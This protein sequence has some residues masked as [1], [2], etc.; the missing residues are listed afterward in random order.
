MANKILIVEDDLPTVEL[1]KFTLQSEGFD[2]V[3]VYDGISALRTV[4]KE[5]PDL[6]LLDVMIPGVDGFEVC[7]LIKHNIKLM[8]IPIIMVTAKVRKEDRQMGFERGA[9]DYISK[10]FDPIEL[11]TRVKKFIDQR[12]PGTVKPPEG[13]KR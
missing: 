13:E 7:Q 12:T 1:L 2:V 11:A 9:D 3:V 5:N 8:H 4:E 6:I 10:P